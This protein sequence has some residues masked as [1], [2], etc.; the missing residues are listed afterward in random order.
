MNGDTNC[1]WVY[2]TAG[3]LESARELGRLLVE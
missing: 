3:S 1:R 2:M